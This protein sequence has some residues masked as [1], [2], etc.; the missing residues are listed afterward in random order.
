MGNCCSCLDFEP[1][2]SPQGKNTSKTIEK[3]K[4]I[5]M[6]R[7]SSNSY[8]YSYSYEYYSDPEEQSVAEEPV[9]PEKILTNSEEP[10]IEEPEEPEKNSTDSYEYESC[11]Y[12]SEYSESE[13]SESEY[14]ESEES[15]DE[16]KEPSSTVVESTQKVSSQ[17]YFASDHDDLRQ[18]ASS[19][20]K[21]A[22]FHSCHSKNGESSSQSSED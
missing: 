13:Y 5:Q 15:F 7:E 11:Y 16:N 22:D 14:S 12:D 21:T 9:E 10:V 17:S 20:T 18:I 3:P 19:S 8:S 4:S 2:E 6:S 1:A